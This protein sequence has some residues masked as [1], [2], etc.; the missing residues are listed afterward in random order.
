MI[1]GIDL[2]TT[3]SLA[4][5]FSDGKAILIPN[6]LGD[7]LTPSVVSLNEKNE[8]LTGLAA[9]ERLS[10]HPENTVSVFKR[11]MGTKKEFQLGKRF[12]RPEEISSFV[13]KSLKQDAEKFLNQKISQAV[14]TVPAYFND[15]QR[16]S[17]KI[18]GE[19][20]GLEVVSLLN[21]P[22]AAAL[23]YGLH[24]S[25]EESK[26]LIFDLGGGTF[27]VSV[28]DYFEGVMEVRSSTGDNFLGGEDFRNILVDQFIQKIAK[29][30]SLP[31]NDSNL[32]E[33]IRFQ[34]EIAKRALSSENTAEMKINWKE[35]TYSLKISSEEFMTWS[36][37]LL[38]RLRRPVERALRDA[39]IKSSELDQ[40]VLAGG[41]TKMPILRKMVA[42]MF[43]IMPASN[44]NPDEIV[45]MGAAVQAGLKM[46]N[47]HLKEMVLTDVCPYTLG[48]EVSERYGKD[49]MEGFYLPIIERNTILPVS[50]SE[51]VVCLH[52]SQRK[53][54]ISIYQ[55][56]SSKVK[57]NVYLGQITV[58]FP[59]LPAEQ[60]KA[61]VRFTY[62]INGILE[63]EVTVIPT[64]EKYRSIIEENPGVLTEKE[65]EE[66]LKILSKLKIHPREQD[67]NKVLISRGERI[68]QESLKDVRMYIGEELKIF[69]AI[70]ET[71]DLDRIAQAREKFKSVLEELEG[72]TFL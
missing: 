22:T 9:R 67:E 11:Y 14:I 36:E 45:A 34:A 20:A 70:L 52:D 5:Y 72:E 17:T 1:L 49:Y 37:S 62:D 50:R 41:A 2:G 26:F 35:K 4:S 48:I 10:T 29:P 54:L 33:M 65:I 21:E 43:G 51:S 63:V 59:N 32:L 25:T 3:N 27:D 23:A 61:E 42:K 57:D 16:K 15:T 69:T 60:N 53:M 7:F 39:R 6:S 44:L 13:L 46:K 47:T 55:G 58:N 64:G 24:N 19:L 71:Q 31:I 56:E 66:R 8:I 30:N 12:Y 40:I 28:L 38:Q 18:A 68:F